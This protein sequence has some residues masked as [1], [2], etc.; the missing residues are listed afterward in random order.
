SSSHD[1][2]NL[3]ILLAGGRFQH[4]GHVAFDQKDNK[5][6]ANLFLRMLR[7]MDIDADRFGAS[8]GIVDE[9]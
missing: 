3:P 4:R 6:M 8:D 7:H 1:N 9:I 5:R 2:N